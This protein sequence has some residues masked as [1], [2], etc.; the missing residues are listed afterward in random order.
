[1]LLPNCNFKAY[2]LFVH[3]NA[4]FWNLDFSKLFCNDFSCI[5]ILLTSKI[6]SYKSSR[7]VLKKFWCTDANGEETIQIFKYL[8]YVFVGFFTLV[9][10]CNMTIWIYFNINYRK[11]SSLP[12]FSLKYLIISHLAIIRYCITPATLNEEKK[13]LVLFYSTIKIFQ[14]WRVTW[15]KGEKSIESHE[16]QGKTYNRT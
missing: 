3:L 8:L 15:W 16:F 1:M 7:K 5:L 11:I 9:E 14:S 13:K 4:F 10:A 6:F 2:L 12:C